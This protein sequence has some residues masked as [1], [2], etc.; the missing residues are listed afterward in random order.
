MSDIS[1]GFDMTDALIAQAVRED[2]VAAVRERLSLKDVLVVAAS[3]LIFV[4]AVH[5]GSHWLWWLAGLPIVI[6]AV[7][8]LG[9]VIAYL[10]LPRAAR[11]KL[12]H[13]PNRRVQVDASAAAL[14]FQTATERLEVGWGELVA[15]KRRP[16]FWIVCLRSGTR[17]PIPAQLVSLEAAAVLSSRLAA[18][19][20]P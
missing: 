15:L 13:L 8:C 3:T 5:R 20:S 12:V 11:S 4:M 14:T 2:C 7:L 10:W 19:V 17:I 1:I 9:W 18:P 6:F 16:N